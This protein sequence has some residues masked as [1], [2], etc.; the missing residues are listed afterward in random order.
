MNTKIDLES[1]AH[2]ESCGRYRHP[3]ICEPCEKAEKLARPLT[4][5]E[6]CT[7]VGITFM[8]LLGMYMVIKFATLS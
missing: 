1:Q 2:C 4:P 3:T 6:A 5:L 7:Y 8:M